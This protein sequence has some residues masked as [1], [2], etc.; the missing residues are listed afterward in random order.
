MPEMD[1]YEFIREV[2]KQGITTPALACNAY[3]RPEDRIRSAQSG[4]QSHLGKPVEMKQLLAV[5]A[6]L[7]GN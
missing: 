6:N 4:Y 1:G 7:A 2:R 5:L 3:V